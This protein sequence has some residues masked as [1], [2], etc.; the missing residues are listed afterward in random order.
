M[1]RA[2][3]PKGRTFFHKCLSVPFPWGRVRDKIE[4]SEFPLWGLGGLRIWEMRDFRKTP[5][6]KVQKSWDK[7]FYP[8]RII[9]RT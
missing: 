5:S 7:Y 4:M 2:D 6:Q 3:F 8:H 9:H 1:A